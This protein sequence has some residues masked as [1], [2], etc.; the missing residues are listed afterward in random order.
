MPYYT[1][2]V[3]TKPIQEKIGRTWELDVCTFLPEGPVEHTARLSLSQATAL[4]S[5]DGFEVLKKYALLSDEV[6]EDGHPFVEGFRKPNGR[7]ES[8][9]LEDELMR[10]LHETSGL[11]WDDDRDIDDDIFKNIPAAQ[12]YSVVTEGITAN[13]E[14]G[15][16]NGRRIL[17]LVLTPDEEEK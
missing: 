5:L 8:L 14:L 11:W 7:T 6:T 10:F 9:E 12:W 3:S 15:P 17:C 16:K 13:S 2:E 1:V 4:D